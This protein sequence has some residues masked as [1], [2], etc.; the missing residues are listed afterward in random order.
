[1]G[2]VPAI[3]S[4][5]KSM[6]ARCQKP[7]HREF[8]YYGGRGIKVCDRW[9]GKD[10]FKHF[11]EDMGERPSDEKERSG[12]SIWS[13]DRI[14]NNKDYCPENCKWATRSE[15]ALNRRHKS[16]GAGATGE[17]H[18]SYE[19]KRTSPKKFRV[20]IEHQNKVVFRQAFETL[21]K[22][23]EARDKVLKDLCGKRG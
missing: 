5:Y 16:R 13:I 2:R 23:V 20:K 4:T 7:N 1:M 8:P 15:Q 12:R 9:L 19:E 17:M 3:Y 22:A 14:D 21:A 6:V 18:I 10:G 11:I